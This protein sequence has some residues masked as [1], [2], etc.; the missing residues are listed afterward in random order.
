VWGAAL[1]GALL[2]GLGLTARMV[3]RRA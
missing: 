3:R 1:L 2:V